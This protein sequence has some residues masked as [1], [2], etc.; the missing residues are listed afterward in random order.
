MTEKLTART[1]VTN[2]NVNRAILPALV[3]VIKQYDDNISKSFINLEFYLGTCFRTK[4]LQK[5]QLCDGKEDC[6]GNGWDESET[7]CAKVAPPPDKIRSTPLTPITTILVPVIIFIIAILGALYWW[8]KRGPVI[9]SE[10]S[11]EPLNH[12]GTNMT[13]V[14]T[15]GK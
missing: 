10:E 9:P 5:S 4:C 6:F 8:F 1:E 3:T 15:T 11:T 12:P 13:T 7:A 2:L 14:H